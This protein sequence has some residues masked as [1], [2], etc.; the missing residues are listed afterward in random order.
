MACPD[1]FIL[2]VPPAYWKARQLL[3]K[4]MYDAILVFMMPYSQGFVGTLLKRKHPE[5]PLILNFDDS[6]TCTD[7][8]PTFPS[9]LHYRFRRWMENHYVQTA[10]ASIY[11]SKTN[12]ERAKA[13]QPAPH[14]SKFHLIRWGS[15]PHPEFSS[16]TKDRDRF[17]ILYL[18][19]TSGWYHFLHDGRNPSLPK[20]LYDRWDNWGRYQAAEL[21]YRTHSPIFIGR[22]VKQLVDRYP[23]W[24]GRIQVNVYGDRYP[25][26]VESAV[27]KRFD[28]NGIVHLNS[29]ISHEEALRRMA[30]SDLLFMALPNR[31]DRTAGGRISAKT[32]EYLSTNRPILAALPPGENREYLADKPG[33]HLT[34]PDDI[35]AMTD[36]IES[37]VRAKFE[38]TPVQVDRS[39]LRPSLSTD[40]RAESF[41]NLLRNTINR[42]SRTRPKVLSSN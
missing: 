1:E 23:E 25:A 35:E 41:E 31:L 39:H 34:A 9:R 14:R 6:P 27:L 17:N 4:N 28:L 7:M 20:R 42:V 16:S 15:K 18:G 3:E 5:L 29:R 38:E 32:Y 24:S 11:V 40:A 12:M 37:H 30:I 21:D 36:V 2:W 8:K 13:R 22:A 33:V 10:D 26:D 19:G